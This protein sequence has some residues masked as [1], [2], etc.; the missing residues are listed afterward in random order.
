MWCRW[1]LV[2]AAIFDSR[3][4]A[5]VARARARDASMSGRRARGQ[6]G[7]VRQIRRHHSPAGSP[8]PM[9]Q[10]VS[11]QAWRTSGGSRPPSERCCERSKTRTCAFRKNLSGPMPLHAVLD[12]TRNYADP[13]GL[14]H[15]GAQLLRTACPVPRARLALACEHRLLR[16]IPVMS[17]LRG[18]RV[19]GLLRENEPNLQGRRWTATPGLFARCARRGGTGSGAV[20]EKAAMPMPEATARGDCTAGTMAF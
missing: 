7:R 11:G 13:W 15:H 16:I 8:G 3:E 12:I 5:R 6:A 4:C 9:R 20:A 2:R 19:V 10:G 18:P 17:I 14:G 1:L